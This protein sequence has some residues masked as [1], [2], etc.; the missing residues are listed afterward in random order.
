MANELVQQASNGICKFAGLS[1]C[2]LLSPLLS[3]NQSLAARPN[4]II[5]Y[6]DDM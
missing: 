2:V 3:S 1:I 4:I 5:I 6:A